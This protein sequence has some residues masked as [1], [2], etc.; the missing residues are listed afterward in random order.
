MNNPSLSLVLFNGQF[1]LTTKPLFDP[2]YNWLQQVCLDGFR[3]LMAL[4]PM[5]VPGIAT[6]MR[7]GGKSS[8]ALLLSV[9]VTHYGNF[10]SSSKISA[11]CIPQNFRSCEDGRQVTTE[12][13]RPA[14]CCRSVRSTRFRADALV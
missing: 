2:F 4:A 8:I 5:L 6:K 12:L 14:Q 9:D 7:R 10:R 11:L 1:E 13:L 3:V